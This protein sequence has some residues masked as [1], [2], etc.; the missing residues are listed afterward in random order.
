MKTKTILKTDYSAKKCK[1]MEGH[2]GYVISFDLHYK[3][4]KCAE[5]FDDGNGGMVSII[6]HDNA[7]TKGTGSCKNWRQAEN[8]FMALV[9]QMG[10]YEFMGEMS[11]YNDEVLVMEIYEDQRSE[12]QL[13]RLLKKKV[14]FINKENG[15]CGEFSWKGCKAITQKHIDVVKKD[16][17]EIKVILNELP[18]NEALEQFKTATSK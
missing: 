11:K 17:S 2:D 6:W 15:K 10:E 3:G 13:K 14:L 5:V 7:M 4:K 12:K 16:C 1:E 9:K 8:D 18:F